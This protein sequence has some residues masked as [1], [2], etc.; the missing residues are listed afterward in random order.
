[1]IKAIQVRQLDD[2]RQLTAICVGRRGAKFI[3]YQA[4]Y[5][6]TATRDGRELDMQQ[7]ID[8]ARMPVPG[9]YTDDS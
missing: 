5:K 1:M 9:K 3:G 2:I 4:V 8:I 7:F 6:S